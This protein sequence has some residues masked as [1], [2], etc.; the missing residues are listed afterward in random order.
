MSTTDR[1]HETPMA[2][3][4]AATLSRTRAL[5]ARAPT[6]VMPSSLPP[7]DDDYEDEGPT[8]AAMR[9]ERWRHVIPSRFQWAQLEDLSPPAYDAD[10]LASLTEWSRNPAGRNLVLFGAV[11]TGKTHAAVAAVRHAFSVG[12]GVVFTPTVEMLDMLRPGGPDGAL[13]YLASADRLI[14][15]DLGSEK[16]TEWTAERMYA[17]VNRR[18]LEERPTIATTN[19]TP[20]DLEETVGA[21]TFSRLIGSGAVT[22]RL[23]GKDRRRR[24]G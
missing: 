20:T 22:V 3:S 2:G 21:R 18:W 11:G 5:A 7:F 23:A 19:L 15:D 13:E 9:N 12:V 1:D 17:L 24:R 14:L 16:A 10:V 4:V 6:P 8:L